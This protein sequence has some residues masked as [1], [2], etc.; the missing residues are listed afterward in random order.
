MKPLL[1]ALLAAFTLQAQEPSLPASTKQK[2]ASACFEVV[3]RRQDEAKD[4]VTYEKPLPWDLVPFNIRN[5][6]YFSIGTAFAVSANELITAHHVFQSLHA[7][8][9]FQTCYIRDADQKVFEVDQILALDE[10][11]D[12]VRFTVKGKTFGNWLDL[13]SNF[14]LNEPVFTVGNAYGEGLIIRP[15]EVIGTFPEPLDGAWNLLKSSAG[16]NPGNSGG[17]LVDPTGKVVGIVLQKKDNLC[18]S[19]PAAELKAMKP[20]TARFF[21][22]VTYSFALVPDKTDALKRAFDIPLPLP[23]PVLRERI[24]ENH[25][26]IYRKSMDSLFTKIGSDLF[27]GGES[28]DEAIQSIPTSNDAELIFR[29]NTTKKWALSGLEYKSADLGKNGAL[30]YANANG[31][32]F[33]RI[34]RPDDVAAIDLVRN[35]KL[36]MDLILKGAP[37]SRTVGGQE[38]RILSF[39]EP[40]LKESHQDRFARPWS[41]S[42][43]YT[44]YDDGLVLSYTALVPSGAVVALKFLNSAQLTEWEYDLPKVLDYT[45]LPFNARFKDW[46]EYFKHPELLPQAFRAI[47]FEFQE[48]RSLQLEALWAKVNLDAKAMEL[49]P[50]AYL[51]LCMG[52]SRKGKDIAWDLRRISF[53]EDEEDNYFVLLKHLHPTASMNDSSQKA[54]K[55]VAKQKHPYTQRPFEEDGHSRIAGLHPAHLKAGANSLDSQELITIYLA[56]SGKVPEG[57]MADRLKR[58]MGSIALSTPAP[59]AMGPVIQPAIPTAAGNAP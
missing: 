12:V 14:V 44:P 6:P 30:R 39:G 26:G 55:E 5:D 18:Y 35:P 2:V 16:V 28:S 58:I 24:N 23:Y 43:W 13:R 48:G 22:K 42:I 3:I 11:R 56:R 45:Y 20:S 19:L 50:N 41:K 38:I 10:Q 17:P 25:N 47:K 4:P 32:Y 29:D 49:A 1:L 8:R 51:G 34:R 27:P 7:S 57:E 21:N 9:T 52:F 40:Y 37:V 54:W 46:K 59:E 15:G 33:F 53:D 36:M 31:V